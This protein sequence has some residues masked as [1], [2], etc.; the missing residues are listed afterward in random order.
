LLSK[1]KVRV[2][3]NKEKMSKVRVMSLKNSAAIE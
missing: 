1:K 2:K 3:K